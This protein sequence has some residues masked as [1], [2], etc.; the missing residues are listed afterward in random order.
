M[1][2]NEESEDENSI[3]PFIITSLTDGI[4]KTKFCQNLIA[5]LFETGVSPCTA[6]FP[7]IKIKRQIV[8][9]YLNGICNLTQQYGIYIIEIQTPRKFHDRY[10][11]QRDDVNIEFSKVF[12][13]YIKNIQHQNSQRA[14]SIFTNEV[15]RLIYSYLSILEKSNSQGASPV[16]ISKKTTVRHEIAIF[17]EYLNTIRENLTSNDVSQNVKRDLQ[18]ISFIIH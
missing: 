17:S 5:N 8:D 18:K 11:L 2:Q 16:Q 12:T 4:G 1:S 6:E 13:E 7:Q 14:K 10:L 15:F 9:H 3:L